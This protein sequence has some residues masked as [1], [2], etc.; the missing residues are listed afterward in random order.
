MQWNGSCLEK[1]KTIKDGKKETNQRRQDM[2]CDTNMSGNNQ[3]LQGSS[4][5]V[6]SV[7]LLPTVRESVSL[8][9]GDMEESG[10]ETFS[11]EAR[12]NMR[13]SLEA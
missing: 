11:C 9:D 12:V 6:L 1:F 3:C 2:C 10:H 8:S 5:S 13:G 4:G 7:V